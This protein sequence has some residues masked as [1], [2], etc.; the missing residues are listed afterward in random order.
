MRLYVA[1]H[2]KILK[3]NISLNGASINIFLVSLCTWSKSQWIYLKVTLK[4]KLVC[5][6]APMSV[7]PCPLMEAN[8]SFSQGKLHLS[9]SAYPH[10]STRVRTGMGRNLTLLMTDT[11]GRNVTMT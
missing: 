11:D 4:A 1:V 6:H 10:P 3:R 7:N 9:V 8:H 2:Q 5:V